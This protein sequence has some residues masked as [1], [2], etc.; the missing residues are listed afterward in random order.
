MTEQVDGNTRPVVAVY[1]SSLIDASRPLYREALTLGELL[2]EA[3]AV[4][5]CGGYAGVMEA[6]SRG[7]VSRGGRAVGYTVAAF[8]G[9]RANPYLSEERPCANLHERLERLIHEA[10]ALVALGG[11][12]G[13]LT[14]VALAWNELYME[15]IKPRP[16]V[17]VGPH[18]ARAIDKLSEFLELRPAHLELLD[19]C[20]DAQEAVALL[21]EKGILE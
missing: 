16:L 19:L 11:G 9:R 6:V 17:L 3:D 4:V 15:L 21:R 13:T 5:A 10:G 7:A 20:A 8:K 12:I 2:A 14:E 1:G 18:W